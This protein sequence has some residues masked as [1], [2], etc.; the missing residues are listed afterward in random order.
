[1]ETEHKYEVNLEWGSGRK[2]II[3]SPVLE[4]CIEVSTPPDFS[5]GVAGI[6]SPEH[7]FIGAVNSCFMTTFLAVAENAN[8]QFTEFTCQ[9]TGNVEKK[10]G[11]FQVTDIILKPKVTVSSTKFVEKALR[12]LEVSEK[13]CLI[14]NSIK[15][16]VYMCPHVEVG[17]N[18]IINERGG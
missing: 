5:K 11:K 3:G 2:G 16:R 15:T 14:S 12:I 18:K 13:N 7:L 6:W 1:M 9:A 17:T 10:E 4:S 8:L